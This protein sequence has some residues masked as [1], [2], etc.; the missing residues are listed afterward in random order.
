MRTL[1][2]LLATLLPLTWPTS[3]VPRQLMGGCLAMA[4]FIL[5]AWQLRRGLR[6]L[7][8][9]TMATGLGF[10]LVLAVD[11]AT[12]APA[13]V[14]KPA[15]SLCVVGSWKM[16]WA[17]G[18]WTATFGRD[19]RYECH[20]PNTSYVGSWRMEADTLH[21]SEYACNQTGSMATLYPYAVR[22]ERGEGGVWRGMG[23]PPGPGVEITLTRMQK[24]N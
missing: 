23:L 7:G 24:G 15:K 22:L 21:V 3:P 2:L 14:P 4:C 16:T 12:A 8:G 19:G 20:S 18:T 1:L 17:G 10:L 11:V 9:F 13:P 6:V 5:G